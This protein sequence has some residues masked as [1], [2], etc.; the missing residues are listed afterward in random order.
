LGLF[1]RKEVWVPTFRGWLLMAV[2]VVGLLAGGVAGTEPFLAANRPLHRGVL[3]VE[4][5]VPDYALEAAKRQFETYSYELVVVAGVPVEHG[6]HIS[7]ATNHAYLAAATLQKLGLPAERVVPVP[8]P[9]VPRNRTY[10]MARKVRE[11]LETHPGHAQVDVLTLGVHARRT[12]LLY[13][14]AL[15][16]NYSAGIIASGDRR[17]D[18]K[19]WWR[20]S[21][22]F[23]TVTSELIA[24][25]YAKLLFNPGAQDELALEKD[26]SPAE[27]RPN[28]A[29]F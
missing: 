27:D 18:P 11:W 26:L 5:W 21:S 25:L 17:Y 19:R 10:A 2:A 15:G 24:Y 29:K 22:G 6:S 3:V 20:T 13:R 1:K 16:A 7:W 4:G 23:R 28:Q 9:E 14:L 8:C 12:W